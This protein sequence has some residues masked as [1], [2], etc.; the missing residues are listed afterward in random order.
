MHLTELYDVIDKWL[1]DY[2]TSEDIVIYE[3][4]GDWHVGGFD[5]DAGLTGRKLA[6]DNYGPRIPVG[7][8]AFS[9]KDPSKVDRSAAYAARQVAVHYLHAR[10]AFDE[11][12]CTNYYAIGIAQPLEQTVIIDG[13]A[14]QIEGI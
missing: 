4:A 5:A 13:V 14:E 1:E 9:G 2:Q 7:G 12:F 11:V 10:Q 6:V 3:L 8:G